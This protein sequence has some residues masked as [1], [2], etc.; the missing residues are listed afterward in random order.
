MAQLFEFDEPHLN[1]SH[2]DYRSLTPPQSW[3]DKRKVQFRE[4]LSAVPSYIDACTKDH[5]VCLSKTPLPSIKVAELHTSKPRTSGERFH[6]SSSSY[7]PASRPGEQ[8]L[9]RSR[10]VEGSQPKLQRRQH[11]PRPVPS[12]HKSPK[13]LAYESRKRE[14]FHCLGN[15]EHT[16]S[17]KLSADDLRYLEFRIQ[18]VKTNISEMEDRF[19]ERYPD[20]DKR[21]NRVVSF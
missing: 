18:A 9:S 12:T 1:T 7:Q 6:R 2:D 20:V 5:K 11:G 3:S 10:I 4:E 19:R 17:T 13:D 16:L 21:L 15:L 14:I 8:S